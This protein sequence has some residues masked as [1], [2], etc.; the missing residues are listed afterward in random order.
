VNCAKCAKAL[1][2]QPI[3]LSGRGKIYSFTTISVGGAP[4]EFSAQQR[5][6]GSYPVA[7]VE[8]EEGPKIV[9]QLT[10]CEFSE[11]K[12]G[13]AVESVFRGIYEEDGIIRYGIKF[14][15]ARIV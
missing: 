3:R 7:V 11:L 14:R 12:I 15:P 10:D 6:S 4:P 2:W 1:E 13:L 9:A 5:F 8:L